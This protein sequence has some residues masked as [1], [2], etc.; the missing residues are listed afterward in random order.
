MTSQF[1]PVF[2]SNALAE[3]QEEL[4]PEVLSNRC[5]LRAILTFCQNFRIAGIGEFFLTANPR[6]LHLRLHQSGRAFAHFLSRADDS[7]KRTSRS[8]PFFDALSAWDLEGA[9]LIAR[10][11][12]RTWVQGEEYEEDFLFVEFLMQHLF[13]RA[14]ATD[15]KA[16]LARYEKALQDADDIRLELCRALLENDEEAFGQ[17]LERFLSERN[18]HYEALAQ[19]DGIPEELRF[20]EGMLSVEGLA[21][22]RLADARGLATEEDY[23]HIPSIARE[24]PPGGLS[25]DA[26][27]RISL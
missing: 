4:L 10:H 9:A 22:V 6:E 25:P 17:S 19:E 21:L 11:S 16:L 26:W 12:R 7:L 18:D 14:S 13:L 2:V 5:T 15:C 8:L 3:N 27:R 24:K 1:L 20:T 23:L